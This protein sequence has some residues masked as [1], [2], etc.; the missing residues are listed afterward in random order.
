MHASN[1]VI[2]RILVHVYYD[3]QTSKINACTI[4]ICSTGRGFV[5]LELSHQTQ[6]TSLQVPISSKLSSANTSSLILTVI[7]FTA[8][9]LR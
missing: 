7:H 9:K 2:F 3:L 8:L 6:I 1:L 5:L 4:A